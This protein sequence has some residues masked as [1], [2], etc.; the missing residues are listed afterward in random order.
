M[1]NGNSCDTL[2]L[3]ELSNLLPNEC[4]LLFF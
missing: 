3:K 1:A 4:Q 2:E